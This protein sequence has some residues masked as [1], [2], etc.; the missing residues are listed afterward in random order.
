[1]RMGRSRAA[2]TAVQVADGA[3]ARSY[4]KPF[5]EEIADT[6]NFGSQPGLTG[7]LTAPLTKIVRVPDLRAKLRIPF[8][9]EAIRIAGRIFCNAQASSI[10]FS[11][12]FK[13]L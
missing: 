13:R 2:L 5:T 8:K 7:S 6:Y 10:Q 11:N 1:M 3:P 9:S 12:N 4:R